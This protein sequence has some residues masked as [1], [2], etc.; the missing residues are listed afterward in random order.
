[1]VK[2]LITGP[3]EDSE[4]KVG[5]SVKVTGHAW[6]GEN[7]VKEMWV[8]T[9]FG[10][11]WKKAQLGK[12]HNKYSWQQWETDLKFDGRGYY[13]IWA[14]AVD[15]KGNTQPIVQPWNPRGY[16]GNAVHRVPVTIQA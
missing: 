10:L 15:D 7:E 13:E 6:A 12:P 9:D 1:V 16:E 8:S 2:S 11:N 5:Q 3:L 14:R 4:F